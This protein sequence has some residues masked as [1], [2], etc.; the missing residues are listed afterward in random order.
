MNKN[1]V[2][3]ELTVENIPQ[4]FV[5]GAKEQLL[6]KVT[7]L[8]SKSRLEFGE[9]NVYATYRRLTVVI[10]NV[11]SKTEKIVEKIY[12]PSARLLKDEKGN[13]TK[14][15]EGFARS[16]GVKVESLKIETVEK[17]GEVICAEKIINAQRAERV[18]GPVFEQAV[19]ELEFPKNMIWEE[20]KFVF[21][22]PIRNILAIYGNKIIPINIAG[23]K[24]SKNTFTSYFTG[25]KSVS[26]RTPQDYMKTLEKNHVIVDDLKRKN[27]IIRIIEGVEAFSK[28]VVNKDE[29]LIEENLYLCE[30]PSGVVVKFPSEFLKLPKE[31][32]NLVMKKQLKFFSCYDK[33]G[34]MLPFFLGIRDG[35]SKGHKNV[36]EGFLNVFK[37]RCSDA[38]FFYDTDMKT[39]VSVFEEKLKKLLFQKELGTMYDKTLRVKSVLEAVMKELNIEKKE[40]SDASSFIYYDLVSSVVNEFS[41]LEGIMNYYYA[42]K[43]GVVD[44]E[45][46][47]AISEI[48]LPNSSDSKLPS[49]I[50]SAVLS[51]SHKIDT[52]VG[53]FIIGA[54]PSGSNDP[55]GLRRYAVGIFR[56]I[57]ENAIPLSMLKLIEFSY[58]S[59][60]Q[61]IKKKKDFNIL[62]AELLDFI[63]QRIESIFE[64][65]GV[66]SDILNS[67]KS[68]FV[69]E[70]DIIRII[71]RIKT[72][73]EIK[74]K[75]DFRNISLL[76]KR[77]KNI[78]K[79]FGKTE[80]KE[81]LFEKE[82]ERI[83]YDYACRIEPSVNRFC[84]DMEYL[85]AVNEITGL[86]E[87]LENFFKNVMVMTENEDVKKNRLAL[88]K[89]IYNLFSEIS[90]ISQI[91]Y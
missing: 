45:I 60:P 29:D 86:T 65:E 75:E 84:K 61:D 6:K 16:C 3:F 1:D 27:S 87:P 13:F 48:Y 56:I 30:H 82:E 18:L 51:L 49:N 8:M 41:E 57:K 10:K 25:F 58:N 21:A 89:K 81:S 71:K 14:A 39:D 52:L 38:I 2:L 83:L 7:E 54:I 50:Y 79:D 9:V 67:V 78:C 31:L 77:L 59:Y 44:E 23:V 32:L 19:K 62:K 42:S 72:L 80:V 64:T 28:C 55:H 85:K 53:D 43:Y 76:Y 66:S 34:N 20:S 40:L 63:Y 88:L 68:I 47:K 46:K 24:S 90:D 91:V 35:V 36:E 73:A 69:R 22:R 12:G 70:G 5:V 74:N 17:K 33:K 15:A 4:R 26:V 11:S 37:A